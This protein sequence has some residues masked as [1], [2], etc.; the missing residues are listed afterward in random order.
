MRRR[1]LAIGFLALLCGCGGGRQTV[2][3]L[4]ADGVASIE[5][6]FGNLPDDR[7]DP[8]PFQAAP[9][10]FDRLLGLL[11]GGASDPQPFKW[12]GLARLR[13]QT[14]ACEEV[15]GWLYQTR[16][17]VGAYQVGRTYY[18]GGSDQEFIRVLLECQERAQAKNR[19]K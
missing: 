16:A 15:V 19:D 12:Q 14:R 5:V 3:G 6:L 10:D 2:E 17:S 9:E 18:R 8:A 11:R 4:P 7:P 1:C 13:I